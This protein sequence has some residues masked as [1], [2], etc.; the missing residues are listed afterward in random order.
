MCLCSFL[1]GY[2]Y[3]GLIFRPE[4]RQSRELWISVVV[5]RM[6]LSKL[7]V[8]IVSQFLLDCGKDELGLFK[9]FKEKDNKWTNRQNV[10][11][12]LLHRD[13][14]FMQL[15]LQYSVLGPLLSAVKELY[16]MDYI[17][18]TL[19]PKLWF[20]EAISDQRTGN[21]FGSEPTFSANFQNLIVFDPFS[22]HCTK[23]K[24]ILTQVYLVVLF[25][26]T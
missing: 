8:L 11:W 15:E 21:K 16:L 20:Y 13:N 1:D 3:Y 25:A 7:H 12:N 23:H 6:W 17:K 9:Y 18:Y 2:Y 22:Q 24:Q 10:M 19:K 14:L 5:V 26:M 4:E